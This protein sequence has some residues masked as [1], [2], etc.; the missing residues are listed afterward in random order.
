VIADFLSTNAERLRAETKKLD[1]AET[2][3]NARPSAIRKS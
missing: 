1:E 2:R 3:G